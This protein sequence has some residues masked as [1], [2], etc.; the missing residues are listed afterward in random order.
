M[1][2]IRSQVFRQ[3]KKGKLFKRSLFYMNS[4]CFPGV[5]AAYL[6][7]P[8]QKYLHSIFF[9]FK[10]CACH[11][12]YRDRPNVQKGNNNHHHHSRRHHH[13]QQQQQQQQHHCRHRFIELACKVCVE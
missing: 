13:H 5:L 9:Y 3:D 11:S 4:N 6:T 1:L 2:L 10:G 8:L 12:N 7:E